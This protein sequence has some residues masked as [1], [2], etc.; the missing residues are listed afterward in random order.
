[1]PIKI[2]NALPAHLLLENENIFVMTEERALSQDIRPLE[3]VILNLMPT[4]ITTET[5]F[6]R[7][8]S[9][10]PLQVNIELLQTAT[11]QSKHTAAEHMLKFYRTLDE[12]K[13]NR[14]DGMIVTGAPVEM[15]EYED[16]D[17]WSEL[18]SIFDWAASHVY[19][20]FHVCW[21]AQAALYHKYGIQKHVLPA[22]MFGVFEHTPMDLKHPLLRGF[23][24]TFYSPHSRHTEIRVS[25][26]ANEPDLSVLAH[27][28]IA[29]VH[30]VADKACRNFYA[31]GHCEYDGNTLALEYFRDKG[32]GLDIAVPYNYFP[33][34]DP[35]QPPL[36]R[37]RGAGSLLFTN[38]LNYFVYQRTPYDLST[39][40]GVDDEL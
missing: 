34:D 22:K 13:D 8:L 26:I 29:G 40:K 4:K 2:D 38:W 33:N 35:T 10:S 18:C 6:L 19:S 37:W 39:L 36:I 15:L 12:I 17:Y 23:D 28:D 9:N 32:K 30:L 5:Q 1:M 31:F 25:D 21:G 27:S 7:L 24:D 14:Y 3:I 20:V 11:H 16:V